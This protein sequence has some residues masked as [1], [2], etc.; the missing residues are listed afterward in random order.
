MGSGAKALEYRSRIIQAPTQFPLGSTGVYS[1]CPATTAAAVSAFPERLLLC[2]RELL[3]RSHR[4]RCPPND[5]LLCSREL[6][7][8]RGGRLNDSVA[9]AALVIAPTFSSVPGCSDPSIAQLRR[10]HLV[11]AVAGGVEE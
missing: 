7:G 5:P 11:V 9:A 6:W 1:K 10:R 3:V 4:S 8:A 2:S